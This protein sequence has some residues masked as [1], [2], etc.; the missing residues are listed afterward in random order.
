MSCKMKGKEYMK[1]K[2]REIRKNIKMTQKQLGKK[3]ALSERQIN[4]IENG[5]SDP[6][7][8]TL[9][10]IASVLGVTVGYL[11]YEEENAAA[12]VTTQTAAKGT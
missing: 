2:I 9:V 6:T 4:R 11:L 7:I 3:T 12:A 1:N 8:K 5:K 10:N